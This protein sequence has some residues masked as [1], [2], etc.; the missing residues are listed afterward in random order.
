MSQDSGIQPPDFAVQG[1]FGPHSGGEVTSARSEL[2]LVPA[3]EAEGQEAGSDAG[4]DL[5]K[6]PRNPFLCTQM[7]GAVDEDHLP[8]VD[9]LE[10][11]T[12]ENVSCGGI[13]FYREGLPDFSEC[14]IALGRPPELTYILARV[15][16][17]DPVFRV[18]CQFLRKLAVDPATGRLVDAE[19]AGGIPEN[20]EFGDLSG[21][22]I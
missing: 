11:I 5:R 18:G 13:A 3:G 19:G 2:P 12:C 21:L 9:E 15:A 20:G 22:V 17:I 10:Q 14:V 6:S 8:A 7:L 16:H 4:A 1:L